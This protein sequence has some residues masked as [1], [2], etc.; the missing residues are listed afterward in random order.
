MG[1]GRGK[2]SGIRGSK[3]STSVEGNDQSDI[4]M[5]ISV[6][7]SQNKI[8]SQN[9]NWKSSGINNVSINTNHKAND[10]KLQNSDV[11]KYNQSNS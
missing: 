5:Q 11:F 8:N 9:P 10:K 2:L 1:S 6:G 4:F 7:D 3:N